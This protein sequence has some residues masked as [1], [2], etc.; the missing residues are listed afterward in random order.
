MAEQLTS[1]SRRRRV[2]CGSIGVILALLFVFHRPLLLSAVHFVGVRVAAKQDL[3]VDFRVEGNVWNALTIRNLHVTPLKPNAAVQAADADYVRAEYNLLA[4]LRGREADVLDALDVRNTTVVINPK[5]TVKP[6]PPPNEKVSLPGIFPKRARLE[7]VNVTVR[8]QPRDLIIR[9]LNLDL[10]PSAPG[11]LRIGQVQLASGRSWSGIAGTTS[12]ENRNLVLRNVALNEQTKLALLNVDASQI[13][14]HRLGFGIDVVLSG[15][16]VHAQGDLREEARSL[17]V[18]AQTKVQQLALASLRQFGI[19][20]ESTNALIENLALDFSGLLSSPKTWKS[21]GDVLVR[22]L[23]VNGITFDRIAARIS[24]HDGVAALQPVEL[25]RASSALQARGEIQLPADARNLGRS[26]AHFEITSNDLDLQAITAGMPQPVIGQA[27]V[28]GV[29]DVHQ[30]RLAADLKISSGALRSGDAGLEKLDATVSCTKELRTSG[31]DLPWFDGVQM[32]AGVIITAPHQGAFA[33][34]NVTAQIEQKGNKVTISHAGVSRGP[35]SISATGKAE[36]QANTSDFTRQPAQFDVTINAPE[37]AAFWSEPSPDRV[38]GA[39]S[40]WAQVTW[41]GETANGSFDVYGAGLQARNLTVPQLSAAGAIW[42]SR[43]FLNDLTASL[44]QHDFVNAHGSLDL[45]G[46]K[47]F[48]GKLAVNIADLSTVKPLLAAT[49]NNTTLGGAFTLN[50]EGSGS[51]ARLAQNGALKLNWT[52]GQLGNMKALQ[53]NI[54]TTYSPAGLEMPTFFIGSDRMDFEAIA[55]AKNERLEISKIQLNQGPTKYAVGSVSIPFIWKNVGTDAPVFP[56]DGNVAATFQAENLD[57]KKISDDLGLPPVASGFVTMKVQADGSLANLHGHLDVDA[58]ELRNPK[59]ANLDPATLRVSAD[60]AQGK[61]NIAGELKQPKIEPVAITAVMPF[62][63]GKL[64][65]THSLDENTPVQAGVRLPRSSVNFLRQFV[66]AIQQLDGTAALDVAIGGTIARPVFSG[67]GD[68]NINV[69]RFSNPTLPALTGYQGRLVFRDNALTL[70][71]FAGDLAG[72]PFVLSGRVLFPKLTEPNLDLTLR[73]DSVLV[74]RN[75]SLTARADANIRVTG[76]FMAALVKGDVALT[77]SH[78]LKNIDIIP[79]GLP[80]RPAPEP[81]ASQ[82]MLSFPDPPLRDWKFDVTVKSKDPF[83][84]NGNLATGDAIIDMKLNGTGLQPGLQGQ[85]RLENFDATLPFSTLTVQY[86]FLYFTPDDPLNPRIELH[87]TSL[88]RDYTIH[89]YIYGTANSPEAVF[90]S[91][92]PL[93][94]EE[95]ISLL[96]TGTTREEL[97]GSGNVLASRAALLLVKQLYAKFFKKGQPTKND[98]FFSR[99]DVGFGTSEQRTSEQT[100]T[101]RFKVTDNIVLVGDVGVAGDFRGQ[102]KYLIRF[103]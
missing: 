61:L 84:I 11:E 23:Q 17:R 93:P 9:D 20:E 66:P 52:H 6:S 71:K 77:N 98:S 97:T 39:L 50:W 100:A 80:G 51:L 24:A 72:G 63:A 103:R 42:R 58:R 32:N 8:D 101:A 60:A 65:S 18:V 57:L 2:V 89:A 73:A 64:L 79:I 91:E 74:A 36:L 12:Y 49:S 3:K 45:A 102:I 68:I 22:D 76:P 31:R 25:V 19:G 87:G 62:D 41:N 33:V 14:A 92:P 4:V 94:Q 44:N 7:N 1:R 75:D 15:G 96:A 48:A 78:F 10:N 26:P 88:I 82:P 56:S 34:D 90:T 46:E 69:A 95:I 67:S 29:I 37:L 83:L 59:F 40:G 27:Q 81:P 5:P 43:V 28:N 99:L 54:D 21:A 86:G 47:N 13:S 35:N 53:A 30:D 16:A 38:A 85:V 55:S 70:E